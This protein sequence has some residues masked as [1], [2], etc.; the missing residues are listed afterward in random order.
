MTT[1]RDLT[2]RFLRSLK[3]AAPGKR[4]IEYDGQVP[5]FGVRVTDRCAD[6]CKGSFVLVTRFPGSK[7]PTAREIGNYPGMSLATARTVARAWLED[8]RQ[9]VDPKA[10]QAEARRQE[11]KKRADTFSATFE[12]FAEDH[13][14]ALRSG[15]AVKTAIA[16]HVTPRWGDR[17]MAEIR[18]ADLIELGRTLKRDTPI[19]ANRI[20]TNLKVFGKW[21]EDQG[22]LESSPFAT[23]KRPSKEN[24]RDRVLSDIEIR[25]KWE[26]CGEL[27]AFGRAF[28]LMLATGQRRTE[29]GGMRWTELDRDRALW[30]LP[31]G[32]TKANRSHEVPLSALALSILD[33]CPRFADFVFSTGKSGEGGEARP[34]S[35]W[36]K[37]KDKLDALALKRLRAWAE[38]RG[39]EPPAELASWHL[40]D[41]RRTCATN[42][43]RLGVDRVVI[44]KILNH[45]EGGVTQIYDRYRYEA[46]KRRG[47]DLWAQRLA[48]IVAGG[49]SANV[50]RLADRMG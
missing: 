6:E 16:R 22:I 35:G 25:A 19:A 45:A 38:E 12:S 20:V 26:A 23:V 13:L 17:P 37:A 11:E 3:P 31:S 2:D 41:L 9:G 50:V 39:E 15:A 28:R 36:G 30:T 34:I 47:L 18:R 29:V 44:A 27:G 46:E 32:R 14:S 40:H 1:K 8:L 7:N 21:L 42:L 10:K 4:Y 33:E 48:A 24:P 43:A 5:H 49:D